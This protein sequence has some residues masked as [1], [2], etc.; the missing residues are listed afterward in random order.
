MEAGVVSYKLCD[1]NFECEDCPFDISIRQHEETETISTG[2][3]RPSNRQRHSGALR[4]ASGGNSI[5]RLIEAYADPILST[6]FPSDRMY[7]AA[8]TWVQQT[9]PHEWI[10]GLDHMGA[11]ALSDVVSVV[12]PLATSS[13]VRHSPFT[14]IVHREGTLSIRS[15]LSG[16]VL[17]HNPT[18]AMEPNAITDDPYGRGWI[19]K[20]RTTSRSP[21]RHLKSSE[22]HT[23]FSRKQLGL[24]QEKFRERSRRC[25]MT[26]ATLYDGGH[27]IQT[28]SELLGNP[29]YY[30]IVQGIFASET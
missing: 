6:P 7:A 18:L 8:H 20:I 15:P 25:E 22:A 23:L 3:S 11:K 19:A 12:L 16:T 14:W 27:P 28:I 24:L 2:G 13:L 26:D 9:N 4:L 10:V 17:A 21:M 29:A 5:E 1:R 30:E